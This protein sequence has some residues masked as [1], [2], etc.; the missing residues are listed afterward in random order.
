MME[1]LKE[2]RTGGGRE[3]GDGLLFFSSLI[4]L[5]S[6]FV[7]LLSSYNLLSLHSFSYSF[8][9][10]ILS[11][12]SSPFFIFMF[13]IRFIKTNVSIII[14]TISDKYIQQKRH[15]R[16]FSPPTGRRERLD[17]P[18]CHFFSLNFV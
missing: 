14:Y 15:G 12:I 5:L 13:I 18:P 3:A 9:G 2:D 16:R 17:E 11:L 4:L 8:P 1:E 6:S 10:F 7:L